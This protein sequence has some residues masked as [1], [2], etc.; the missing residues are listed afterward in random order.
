[1]VRG[2]GCGVS[3]GSGPPSGGGGWGFSAS[4]ACA[5]GGGVCVVMLSASHTPQ[6]VREWVLLDMFLPQVVVVGVLL[7]CSCLVYPV[8][9]QSVVL[10]SL[11]VKGVCGDAHNLSH[12]TSVC[13]CG[14]GA[15]GYVP[16]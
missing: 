12:S 15:A 1:M 3:E 11:V 6:V 8:D 5:T 4:A 14:G 13:V 7:M 9:P 16:A 2:P 10:V